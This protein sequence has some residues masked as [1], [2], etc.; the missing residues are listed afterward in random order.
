MQTSK[1]EWE[2]TKTSCDFAGTRQCRS[3]SGNAATTES[4]R[5]E[6]NE[7][8]GKDQRATGETPGRREASKER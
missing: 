2:R 4:H 1:Q 5:R 6:E 8:D 3:P 7:G